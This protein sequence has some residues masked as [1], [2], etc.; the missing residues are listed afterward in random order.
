MLAEAEVD[1]HNTIY[2][3]MEVVAAPEVMLRQPLKCPQDRNYRSLWVRPEPAEVIPENMDLK[4]ETAVQ[5]LSQDTLL[6]MVELEDM[7]ILDPV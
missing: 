5:V 4:A 6:V 7:D 1:G 2:I 3:T